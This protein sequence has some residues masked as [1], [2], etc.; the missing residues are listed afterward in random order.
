MRTSMIFSNRKGMEMWIV[1]MMIL[2]LVV[3]AFL[4]WKYYGAGG[5]FGE[6][7]NRAYELEGFLPNASLGMN[8]LNASSPQLTETQESEVNGLRSTIE[9]M[10]ASDKTDCFD[11]FGGFK[12]DLGNGDKSSRISIDYDV[13]IQATQFMVR[14]NLGNVVKI[15]SVDKMRPCVIAGSNNAAVNFYNH[16]YWG[17]E[18]KEPY[19]TRVDGI[20]ISY[21]EQWLGYSGN[22]IRIAGW[23]E[24]E[25]VNKEWDNFQSNLLFKGK[26]NEICFFPTNKI[27]DADFNGLN[28]DFFDA[29][30]TTS[31]T[32]KLQQGQLNKC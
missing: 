5:F 31:F 29:S 18:L 21:K 24:S 19:Y 26:N 32:Y 27:T 14:N 23:L 6:L 30:D 28:N 1:V 25:P 9:R 3:F 7:K 17:N 16:F 20:E 11:D 4:S 15:F 10:L 22:V 12:E 13:S 2:A 8:A